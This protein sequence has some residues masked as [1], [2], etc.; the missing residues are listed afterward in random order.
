MV[1]KILFLI[2]SNT[3]ILFIKKQFFL[4]SYITAKVLFINNEVH[5][6]NKKEHVKLVL[7]KN[8]IIFV[9]QVATLK[10]LESMIIFFF[11]I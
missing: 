8:C 6:I 2:Y 9:M 1:L 4:K 10:T 3:N 11:I 7:D 5:F